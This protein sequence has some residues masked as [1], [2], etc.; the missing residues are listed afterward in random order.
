MRSYWV[1][2]WYNLTPDGQRETKLTTFHSYLNGWYLELPDHWYGQLTVSRQD[3]SDGGYG[4]IFSKWNGREE[5][6]EQIVTVYAFTGDDRLE[7]ANADGRFLLGEKGE[8]VYAAAFGD[9]RWALELTKEEFCT[10]FHFIEV[11]WNT[12]EI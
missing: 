12:G 10:M 2:D 1:I 3:D 8:T 9:C 5:E 7:R 4:Y 6:P 11:D